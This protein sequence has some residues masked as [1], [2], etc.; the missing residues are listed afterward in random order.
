MLLYKGILVCMCCYYFYFL[1]RIFPKRHQF[2]DYYSLYS[3]IIIIIIIFL[4]IWL[5][6]DFPYLFDLIDWLNNLFNNK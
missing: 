2:I 4:S 3:I 5:W 1:R 6:M